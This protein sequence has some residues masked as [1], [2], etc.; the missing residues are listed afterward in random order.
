MKTGNL[1]DTQPVVVNPVDRLD[2]GDRVGSTIGGRYRLLRVLGQ[3][4]MGTVYEAE[5]VSLAKRLAVKTMRPGMAA[6]PHQASRFM[7]EAQAL[8]LLHHPH[9]VEVF[10]FG[11]ADGELFLVMELLPGRPLSAWLA[12]L[13]TSPPIALV[14]SLLDQA[15]DAIEM[16][17]RSGIIH[18]DLKPDNLF[19]S[20]A[21]GGLRLTLVDFGLAHVDEA[22]DRVG[23]LTSTGMI[24]GTPLYM[25]PE[26]C[27]SLSVSP[28]SD[29]YSL[30]CILTEMLQGTPPFD[31]TSSAELMAQHMF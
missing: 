13:P 5:H 19:L 31:A 20:D 11:S 1:D 6:D 14:A 12:A 9:I 27:R 28:S 29:L 30:G 17:H 24:A 15:L 4:G 18:R 26:Q 21:P 22:I 23:K 3:G 8:A 10:D 25:S 2:P 7:R 16:A